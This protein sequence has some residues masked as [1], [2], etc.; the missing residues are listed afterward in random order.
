MSDFS[1]LSQD[2]ITKKSM[3]KLSYV[4]RQRLKRYIGDLRALQTLYPPKHECEFSKNKKKK[5]YKKKN[6]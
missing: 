2:G 4:E 1:D 5:N 6:N 3:N